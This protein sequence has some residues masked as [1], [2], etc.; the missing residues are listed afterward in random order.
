MRSPRPLRQV[1]PRVSAPA[2]SVLPR[3][4]WEPGGGG[5]SKVKSGVFEN[6]RFTLAL[7]MATLVYLLLPF[8][9]FVVGWVVPIV[10]VPVC[11]AVLLGMYFALLPALASRRCPGPR[12]AQRSPDL[13]GQMLSISTLV[14]I[15]LIVVAYSGVGGY[16]HQYPDYARHNSFLRDLIEK[17]WP[18]AY[19]AT[20]PRNEPGVL[21]FYIANSLTP[22][23]VGKVFGWGSAN[24]FSLAWAVLGVF[25][26]V[27][28]FL[29]IMGTVSPIYGVLFLF[30]GGLDVVGHFILVGWH[31]RLDGETGISHWMVH[32]AFSSP[33]VQRTMRGV[34]WLV[35]S[36]MDLLYDTPQHAFSCWLSLLVILYD[37]IYG[38][39]CYRAILV[40]AACLLWSAFSFVGIL[41]FVAV[42]VIVTRGK[43]LLSVPNAVAAPLILGL[44]VLFVSSNNH[45]YVHGWLWQFQDVSQTWPALILYY[46]IEF[47]VYVL[48]CAAIDRREMTAMQPIWWWTAIGCLLILPWYRLGYWN[49]LSIKASAP[50]AV[51]MLVYLAEVVRNAQTGGQ[52]IGAKVLIAVMLLGAGAAVDD[53]SRGMR[54]GLKLAPPPLQSIQHVNDQEP[55]WLGAQLFSRG[56]TFFWRFLAKPLVPR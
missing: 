40:W 3:D 24:L 30:F 18:L 55:K 50:S 28:W 6:V 37:A 45:D 36:N 15:I 22:A 14:A 23:L 47:G 32:Y 1:Q 51:V 44:T 27:C 38:R 33:Q 46:F 48:I 9:I 54:Q 19:T 41:P 43:G 11:A 25:L 53:V 7:E 16:A 52:R 56:D 12:S 34:F 8:L 49:D 2:N 20:G 10:A 39:T 4:P 35:P 42:A 21:A 13:G 5:A 26:A 17:P 29:R 31:C